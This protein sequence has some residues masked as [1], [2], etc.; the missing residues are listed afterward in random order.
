LRLHITN[1]KIFANIFIVT[2]ILQLHSFVLVLQNI[3]GYTMYVCIIIINLHP[4]LYD[5]MCSLWIATSS[6]EDTSEG[7]ISYSN[8]DSN[9]NDHVVVTK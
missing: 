1:G 3:F 9:D 8:R 5:D 4:L 7:D 6:T 2:E